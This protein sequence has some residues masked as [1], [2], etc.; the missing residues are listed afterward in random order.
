MKISELENYLAQVKSEIGD[1]DIVY[2]C[3][4]QHYSWLD[5]M[6]SHQLKVLKNTADTK[7]LIS[8]Q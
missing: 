5:K 6:R 2:Q 3:H 7:L 4:S 8:L 1:I